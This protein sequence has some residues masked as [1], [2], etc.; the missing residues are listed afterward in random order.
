[1][2][3]VSV[4]IFFHTNIHEAVLTFVYQST[5]EGQKGQNKEFQLAGIYRYINNNI[6]INQ[7][8]DSGY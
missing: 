4:Y 8:S 5:C 1:M 6:E 3:F 7:K 2:I